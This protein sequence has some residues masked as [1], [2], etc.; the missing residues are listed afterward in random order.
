MSKLFVQVKEKE[1]VKVGEAK[2]R[3]VQC[4]HKNFKSIKLEFDAPTTVKIERPNVSPRN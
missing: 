2:V 4:F 3:W 1:W